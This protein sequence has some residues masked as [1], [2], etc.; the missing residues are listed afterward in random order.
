MEIFENNHI[1]DILINLDNN[2]IIDNK[3]IDANIIFLKKN[4]MHNNCFNKYNEEIDSISMLEYS[5][6]YYKNISIEEYCYVN[7]FFKEII[8][9]DS[10]FYYKEYLNFTFDKK[11]K[12]II[13]I[14]EHK[15]NI[16]GIEQLLEILKSIHCRLNKI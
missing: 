15:Q 14:M 9:A 12:I 10:S 13:I 3:Q 1:T 16:K 5:I 8:Y 2:D 6:L 4:I 11:L 7:L